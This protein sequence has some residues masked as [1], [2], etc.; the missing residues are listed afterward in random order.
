MS[1]PHRSGVV[2]TRVTE[3]ELLAIRRWAEHLGITVS[4]LMRMALFEKLDALLGRVGPMKTS[5]SRR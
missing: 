1:G 2:Q 3:E 4:E 5:S